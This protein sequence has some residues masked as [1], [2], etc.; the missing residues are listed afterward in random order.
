MSTAVEDPTTIREA[1][2]QGF[3]VFN[4]AQEDL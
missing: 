2:Q 4:G 1:G 3:E